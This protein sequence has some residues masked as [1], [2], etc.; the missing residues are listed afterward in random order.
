MHAS[1]CSLVFF[2]Q[3]RGT[4][5]LWRQGRTAAR[6]GHGVVTAYSETYWIINT[7]EI[8]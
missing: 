3:G 6:L 7:L 8:N 2:S 5:A 4:A 1:A